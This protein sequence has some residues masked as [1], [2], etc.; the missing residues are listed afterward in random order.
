ML[1]QASVQISDSP[2][3]GA[4]EWIGVGSI[5]ALLIGSISGAI[6]QIIR[7]RKDTKSLKNE[8]SVL[9]EENTSQHGESRALVTDVRDRLLDLHGAVNRVDSKVDRI[10][11]RLDNHFEWHNQES[12]TPP[13]SPDLFRADL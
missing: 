4:A 7:L 13:V 10:D 9:R 5:V 6:I 11:E 3:W 8:T 1:A 2:G 12:K